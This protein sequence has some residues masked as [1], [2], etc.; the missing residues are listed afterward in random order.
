MFSPKDIAALAGQLEHLQGVEDQL[1]NRR[2]NG[3]IA[4]LGAVSAGFLQVIW[5]VASSDEEGGFAAY[6]ERV[7]ASLGATVD[8]L[9]SSVVSILSGN[10][11]ELHFAPIQYDVLGGFLILAGVTA[12]YLNRHT[13][14]LFQRSEEPFRYTFWIKPFDD[15]HEDPKGD[16]SSAQQSLDDIEKALNQD[17]GT[18]LHHDLMRTLNQRIGRFSILEESAEATEDSAQ[19]SPSHIHI[20]GHYA[21]RNVAEDGKTKRVVEVMPRIRIGPSGNASTLTTPARLWLDRQQRQAPDG[22]P[23]PSVEDAVAPATSE[24]DSEGAGAAG[25]VPVRRARLITPAA[26]DYND[27]LE[28][29]Y[30]RLASE[31]YKQLKKDIESKLDLFPTRH[32]RAIALFHEACD[33]A[34]SNTIDSYDYAIDLYR[35]S[36]RYY[37]VSFRAV[38]AKVPLVSRFL[39]FGIDFEIM[40]SRVKVECAKSQVFRRQMSSLTGRRRNSLYDVPIKL[41]EVARR[42]THIHNKFHFFTEPIQYRPYPDRVAVNDARAH[43]RNRRLLS[44]RGLTYLP[45]TWFRKHIVRKLDLER[46]DQCKRVMFDTYVVLGMS[47]AELK[48]PE[49]ANHCLREAI[50]ILPEERDRNA[51]FLLAR[52]EADADI[53]AK[54]PLL[55]LATELQPTFEIARYN[56]AKYS[57]EQ[58]LMNGDIVE[59]RAEPVVREFEEVLK[60]N[61]SNVA[62][63]AQLGNLYWL[64]QKFDKA[65]LHFE[66]G[67]K[68]KGIAQQTFV[69]ELQYGRA[70]IAARNGNINRCHDFYADA[71][72]AEPGVGAYGLGESVDKT[73]SLSF[74]DFV[75]SGIVERYAL[76]LQ[77]FEDILLNIEADGALSMA[78][79]RLA[80]IADPDNVVLTVQSD[81]HGLNHCVEPDI[82]AAVRASATRTLIDKAKASR[83]Y[84]NALVR[85]RQVRSDLEKAADLERHELEAIERAARMGSGRLHS[86]TTINRQL[87]DAIFDGAIANHN[88]QPFTS[89]F[90]PLAQ[91]RDTSGRIVTL[92]TLRRAL[93]YVLNDYGNACL[94]YFHRHGSTERLR[95][96]L[97]VYRRAIDANPDNAIAYY[98]CENA[99]MWAMFYEDGAPQPMDEVRQ[100]ARR[101]ELLDKANRLMG[102]QWSSAIIRLMTT[103]MDYSRKSAQQKRHELT[104]LKENLQ[105]DKERRIQLQEKIKADARADKVEAGGAPEES[106]DSTPRTVADTRSGGAGPTVTG[107]RSEDL[108]LAKRI[109]ET[110]ERIEQYESL[111]GSAEQSVKDSFRKGLRQTA[112]ISKLA[113]IVDSRDFGRE[114]AATRR[115]TALQIPAERVS[116]DDIEAVLGWATLL[117]RY[118]DTSMLESSVELCKFAGRYL[119][120]Q[121]AVYHTWKDAEELLEVGRVKHDL[122]VAAARSAIREI[123]K[124]VRGGGELERDDTPDDTSKTFSDEI[125]ESAQ[126]L[127]APYFTYSDIRDAYAVVHAIGRGYRCCVPENLSGALERLERMYAR[128]GTDSA[129]G[130][131]FVTRFLNF[132]VEDFEVTGPE[133][134]RQARELPGYR[135]LATLAVD[136]RLRGLDRRRFNRVLIED[137]LGSAVRRSIIVQANEDLRKTIKKLW[138]VRDPVNFIS[139]DN[140]APSYLL[141]P[142]LRSCLRRAIDA[143]REDPGRLHDTHARILQR[144]DYAEDVET[145]L[146]SE[147]GRYPDVPVYRIALSRLL[148]GGTNDTDDYPE[149]QEVRFDRALDLIKEGMQDYSFAHSGEYERELRATIAAQAKYYRHRDD[150]GNAVAKSAEYVEMVKAALSK[151]P[152]EETGPERG[153]LAD[154][155]RDHADYLSYA[156][157]LERAVTACDEAISGLLYG[158]Q[159]EPVARLETLGRLIDVAQRQA[160]HLA[161][162]N[163]Y[164]RATRILNNVLNEISAD[165][166]AA[167]LDQAALLRTR[168][169]SLEVE[170][171]RWRIA[172]TY[173]QAWSARIPMPTPI[174]VEVA[175]N[176]APLFSADGE[177]LVAD[178][179]TRAEGLRD[180][181]QATYGFGVPGVRFRPNYALADGEYRVLL[182]NSPVALRRVRISRR[183]IPATALPESAEIESFDDFDPYT[184]WAGSWLSAEDVERLGATGVP[185]LSPTDYIFSHIRSI[186]ECN[187][188]RFVDVQGVDDIL[189]RTEDVRYEEFQHDSSLMLGL[190]SVVRALLADRVPLLDFQVIVE[191][192]LD[193]RALSH[194]TGHTIWVLRQAMET[195][196]LLPVNQPGSRVVYVPHAIEQR[197]LDASID[198]AAPGVLVLDAE[199]ASAIVADLGVVLTGCG[200]EVLV[201]DDPQ[202]RPVVSDL[203]RSAFPNVVT[204]WSGEVLESVHEPPQLAKEGANV[205]N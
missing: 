1:R 135:G 183:F 120:D 63:Y 171:R 88:E 165:R 59:E 29:V 80:D 187:L 105:R 184:G 43:I 67:I 138:L 140:W 114:L 9:W 125:Y 84:L 85:K 129:D 188:T 116:D 139:I 100:L 14:F 142:E 32:L 174:A 102:W 34:R 8:Y 49:R 110:E 95:E 13:A 167:I 156:G 41:R 18:F 143:T 12:W 21:I 61:P 20:D 109:Y 150:P 203:I 42:L 52:A 104:G 72:A 48:S 99:E 78:S 185:G 36:L 119:P 179:E 11:G 53:A 199:V 23:E 164:E 198:S 66:S 39:R 27:L 149:D 137:I 127:R 152:P 178:V 197:L 86:F 145:N 136:G 35:Q 90:H 186:I 123:R 169:D 3:T 69:G 68:T 146:R 144:P 22:D 45:D 202:L 2:R 121:A 115:L 130:T 128:P 205:A 154:A 75:S 170:A 73:R 189:A 64:L 37:E 54:I 133:C 24:T 118:G 62:T 19:R 172:G 196:R 182:H 26:E 15:A 177:S 151:R 38:L 94:N 201:F 175:A 111:V 181:I 180:E 93:S 162:L 46:F 51:L 7:W 71:L 160:N 194:P 65:D 17:L 25:T 30:A 103:E 33:F 166:D 47:Y 101:V 31:V 107:D 82:V 161:A 124:Q 108:K 195:R 28:E 70:K 5:N 157:H 76:Y 191:G 190:T 131:V 176:L 40:L 16:A 204:A 44:I 4:T 192:F 153:E 79:I 83:S 96:A 106:P 141:L 60:V 98:N 200:P 117:A 155:L 148:R 173:G 57:L 159:S 56:L 126:Q 74:F 122:D 50:S 193:G 134:V 168:L 58:F 158:L 81:R 91:M 113:A 147:L 163:R 77:R 89:G 87:L 112:K 10:L 97:L 132:L 92:D 55:T 6:V